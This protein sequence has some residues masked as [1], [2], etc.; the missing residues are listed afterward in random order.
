MDTQRRTYYGRL[1]WALNTGSRGI[2]LNKLRSFQEISLMGGGRKRP[3][4]GEI[5][6]L[7]KR[8]SVDDG[9]PYAFVIW[10]IPYHFLDIPLSV[11][12]CLSILIRTNTSYSEFCMDLYRNLSS[13]Q[14][15]SRGQ[16]HV[17]KGAFYF[18]VIICSTKQQRPLFFSYSVSLL[19][20]RAVE[21]RR[22]CHLRMA[23]S[24]NGGHL[25]EGGP[26]HSLGTWRRWGS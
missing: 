13:L 15:V 25:T 20:L 7:I 9:S 1:W 11:P 3:W 19:L 22:C 16:L 6:S 14:W 5:P 8:I 21:R 10:W 2:L 12:P 24:T 23:Q 26:P 4:G 18:F 17:G